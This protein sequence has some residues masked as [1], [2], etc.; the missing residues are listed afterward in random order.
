MVIWEIYMAASLDGLYLLSLYM[1][2]GKWERVQVIS[3][4]G[5]VI[6]DGRQRASVLMARVAGL[7]VGSRWSVVGPRM[8]SLGRRCP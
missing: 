4:Q 1:D 2:G 5:S 6:R 3:D 7:V 8:P